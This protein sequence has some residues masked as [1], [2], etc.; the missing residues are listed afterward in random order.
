MK[1][2][3]DT[4]NFLKAFKVTASAAMIKDVRPILQNVKITADEDGNVSLHATNTEVGIRIDVNATVHNGGSVLIPPK[5]LIK[6]LTSV[7][8]GLTV[9]PITT[10]KSDGETITVTCGERHQ[11]TAPVRHDENEFPDVAEFDS[12]SYHSVEFR[13][14]QESIKRTLA[15]VDK[16]AAPYTLSGVCFENDGNSLSAMATD[17][18]RMAH[19]KM[20]ALVSGNH[21]VNR[22][23]V[24]YRALNLLQKVLPTGKLLGRNAHVHM[25]V[26]NNTAFFQYGNVTIFSRLLEGR[27]PDMKSYI[28]KTENAPAVVDRDELLSAVKHMRIFTTDQYPCTVFTFEHGKLT[29][30]ARGAEVGRCQ[31]SISI[32]YAGEKQSVK[33]ECKLLLDMLAPMSGAV[34]IYLPEDGSDVVKFTAGDSVCLQMSADILP[35]ERDESEWERQETKRRSQALRSRLRELRYMLDNARKDSE[36]SESWIE[37]LESAIPVL[38]SKCAA[39]PPDD[40]SDV[41]SDESL[42]ESEP[43]V[44]ADEDESDESAESEPADVLATL[45]CGGK[46]DSCGETNCGF[47]PVM[48]K[49]IKN[50]TLL[51]HIAGVPLADGET[52][53]DVFRRMQAD[54]SLDEHDTETMYYEDVPESTADSGEWETDDEVR[55]RVQAEEE[56]VELDSENFVTWE[57]YDTLPYLVSLDGINVN[58]TY[59]PAFCPDENLYLAM[60]DGDDESYMVEWQ[61]TAER[62]D[63]RNP[64]RIV[65]L[66]EYNAENVS[67]PQC[68]VTADVIVPE[69]TCDVPENLTEETA[70]PQDFRFSYRDIGF[71]WYAYI[72]GEYGTCKMQVDAGHGDTFRKVTNAAR[73]AIKKH[74]A[75]FYVIVWSLGEDEPMGNV[76]A[77]VECVTWY[78][79]LS[80]TWLNVDESEWRH[81]WSLDPKSFA[82]R[83]VVWDDTDAQAH[84]SPI[85]A[86]S[87]ET[88]KIPSEPAVVEREATVQAE[89]APKPAIAADNV[90]DAKSAL[91]EMIHCSATLPDVLIGSTLAVAQWGD[92]ATV[93]GA[94]LAI[95][96]RGQVAFME[97]ESGRIYRIPS[98][99]FK[100]TKGRGI[101]TLSLTDKDLSANLSLLELFTARSLF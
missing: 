87:A 1:I 77:S 38:E 21:K 24:T 49:R 68:H 56:S 89:S 35:E 27:F 42:D 39:L 14:M 97:W 83:V 70:E 91:D 73:K 100:R 4:K 59:R 60:A 12:D 19:Y 90:P 32:E 55:Q 6:V 78:Q 69:S 18:K 25:A 98:R 30:S 46:C 11:W 79:E 22:A 2:S 76:N 99:C 44:E 26:K 101:A 84:V 29:L 34:L 10:L 62:C 23:V 71:Y 40:E 57:C 58:L 74:N 41:E 95:K 51:S 50:G 67:N 65:T 93:G 13:D 37:Y 16:K 33:L 88:D 28:P 92:G 5:W 52:D 94:I 8:A 82:S 66:D 61:G 81:Y 85:E 64:C 20:T 75:Q 3:F 48:M 17:G 63:W 36:S 45:P 47:H 96:K 9:S 31:N 7:T 15:V 72:S 80:G 54:E 43:M 53:E 86:E